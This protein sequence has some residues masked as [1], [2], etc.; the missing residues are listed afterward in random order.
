MKN[1]TADLSRIGL[2]LIEIIS[3]HEL[4][5]LVHK[6]PKNYMK[7]TFRPLSFANKTHGRT[8]YVC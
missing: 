3:L 8:T 2:N 6:E 5:N 4:G 7:T 1:V